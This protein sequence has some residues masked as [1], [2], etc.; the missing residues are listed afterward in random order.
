MCNQRQSWSRLHARSQQQAWNPAVALN[1]CQCVT[2]VRLGTSTEQGSGSKCATSAGHVPIQV[3]ARNL[4]K[5]THR[6]H[7]QHLCSPGV[8]CQG[9][10]LGCW[11][12]V[13]CGG[14]CTWPRGACGPG[15]AHLPWTSLSDA[16]AACHATDGAFGSAW[17]CLCCRPHLGCR[18]CG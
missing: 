12:G 9:W 16:G 11:H 8:L 5:R 18:C 7:R 1:S 14:W 17:A 4:W 15:E 6:Q 3:E 10:H 2:S 13:S